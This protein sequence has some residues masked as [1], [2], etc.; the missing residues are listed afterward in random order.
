[1]IIIYF[2]IQVLEER[3]SSLTN[4]LLC[5]ALSLHRKTILQ[6]IPLAGRDL[7][8]LTPPCLWEPIGI[9]LRLRKG[10]PGSHQKTIKWFYCK[11][12]FKHSICEEAKKRENRF[13]HFNFWHMCGRWKLGLISS[14]GFCFKFPRNVHCWS[15]KILAFSLL[16]C[17]TPTITWLMLSTLFFPCPA[18]Y[19]KWHA[20]TKTVQTIGKTNPTNFLPFFQN[21]RI[22]IWRFDMTS[23]S[24]RRNVT[25]SWGLSLEKIEFF[26]TDFLRW[27]S[28]PMPQRDIIHSQSL[29][30]IIMFSYSKIICRHLSA[31][32]NWAIFKCYRI[33]TSRWKP[34]ADG[35]LCMKFPTNYWPGDLKTTPLSTTKLLHIFIM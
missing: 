1:M 30:T 27:V 6:S 26:S 21:L 34:R 29:V 25:R 28:F 14:S 8:Q 15:A 31:K 23:K 35:F 22:E 17:E 12:F 11:R 2:E 24:V 7:F 13:L 16:I 32:K 9:Y 18:T 20:I 10:M 3:F 5:P 4:A 33:S 19:L